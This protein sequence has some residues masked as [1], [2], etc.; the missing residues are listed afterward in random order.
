VQVVHVLKNHRAILGS[1]SRRTISPFTMEYPD[2]SVKLPSCNITIGYITKTHFKNLY[3][4]HKIKIIKMQL[5]YAIKA[6]TEVMSVVI[7]SMG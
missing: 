7:E 4:K 6:Y 3:C 1:V 2:S 5:M